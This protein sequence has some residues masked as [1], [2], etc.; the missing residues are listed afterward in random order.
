[1]LTHASSGMN[2]HLFGR[3]HIVYPLSIEIMSKRLNNYLQMYRRRLGL[4]QEEVAFL[5]GSKSGTKISRYERGRRELSLDTAL[6]FEAIYGI[7]LRELFAGRFQEVEALI[8]KR[9][10]ALHDHPATEDWKRKELAAR[11]K[12]NEEVV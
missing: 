2:S 11:I 1:M 4:S 5:L 6:A 12:T 10:R 9:V 7:P 8:S 3:C